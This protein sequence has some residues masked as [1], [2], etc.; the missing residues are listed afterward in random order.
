[1][2]MIK[3]N[4]LFYNIKYMESNS[5]IFIK[6]ESLRIKIPKETIT[7]SELEV[8]DSPNSL[9]SEGIYISEESSIY[10]KN[11]LCVD[12]T[13]RN[14]P[15][16][17]FIYQREY[18]TYSPIRFID[19]NLSPTPPPPKEYF[20]HL[21]PSPLEDLTPTPPPPPFEE[22]LIP[23][24]PPPLEED[25]SSDEYSE[26]KPV[27]IL[28]LHLPQ[29]NLLPTE[30]KIKIPNVEQSNDDI[31]PKVNL[32]REI[33]S[34]I[35]LISVIILISPILIPSAIIYCTIKCSTNKN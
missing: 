22:N 33:G 13:G 11:S 6:S 2:K 24:P 5:D 3:I 29:V 14:Y 21:P 7:D 4:V 9:L 26:E 8:S 32:L 30:L 20:T 27:P 34:S 10:E 1:M 12:M 31:K 17:E 28:N 15:E 35:L 25:L 18:I 16:N 19:E 23:P